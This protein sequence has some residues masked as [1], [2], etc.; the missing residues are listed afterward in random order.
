MP[1]L[2][3]SIER[4]YPDP[5]HELD[6]WARDFLRKEGPTPTHELLAGMTQAIKRASPMSRARE[7]ACRRRCR[8]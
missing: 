4:Q 7:A 2:L 5:D 6:R 3:R 1:D 8:R